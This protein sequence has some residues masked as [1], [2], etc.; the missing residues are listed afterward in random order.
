[1]SLRFIPPRWKSALFSALAFS[2]F[3]AA[4]V[5]AQSP[6]E[7]PARVQLVW[8][9]RPIRPGHKL[10][11]G[12]LFRLKPGWHIYWQNP[13]D[14]GEPPKIQWKLPAGFNGGDILWPRPIL[15][16]KGS[17]RDYGYEGDVLLMT[18]LE[19]PPN[20]QA[21]SPIVLAATLTYVACREICIPGKAEVTL[22]VPLYGQPNENPSPWRELFQI[23]RGQLPK[24]LPP[25]WKASAASEGENFVLTVECAGAV[26]RV[27]FFPLDPGVI[28]NAAPQIMSVDD[29]T[30]RLMLKKSEQLVKPLSNL[31]GVIVF[32]KNHAYKIDA[33][34]MTTTKAD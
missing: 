18:P 5:N 33:P 4:G 3:F 31:R 7:H 29:K 16:G 20:L 30:V 2:T 22:S 17:V 13:G 34:V 8:D 26:Q 23:T 19:T 15:L 10:W 11:V 32:D 1:M 21:S 28:E 6:P 12:V 14:S 24:P 27:I 9:G 25:D